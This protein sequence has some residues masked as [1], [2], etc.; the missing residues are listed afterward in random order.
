MIIVVDDCDCDGDLRYV[1]TRSRLD[2]S[3][4]GASQNAACKV[5]REMHKVKVKVKREMHN[6]DSQIDLQLGKRDAKWGKS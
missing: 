3:H 2:D 5:K 6:W 4:R 1:K